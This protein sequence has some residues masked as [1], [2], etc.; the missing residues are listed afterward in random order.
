MLPPV[1]PLVLLIAIKSL[2]LIA[3]LSLTLPQ[4]TGG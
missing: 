4:N 2:V 3:T 1:K